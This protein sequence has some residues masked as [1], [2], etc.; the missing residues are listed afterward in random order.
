MNF[1]RFLKSGFLTS[2]LF[3]LIT[4][5]NVSAIVDPANPILDPLLMKHSLYGETEFSNSGGSTSPKNG[6][7]GTYGS[8]KNPYNQF[9]FYSKTFLQSLDQGSKITIVNATDTLLYKNNSASTTFMGSGT[10]IQTPNANVY[11]TKPVF[12]DLSSGLSFTGANGS[13]TAPGTYSPGNYTE[14][15]PAWNANT[16]T[17]TAG[18]YYFGKISIGSSKNIVIAPNAG[19]YLTIIYI[20]NS[21]NLNNNSKIK[22]ADSTGYGQVLFMYRG[23]SDFT[24]VS[25][26]EITGT[27]IAPNAKIAFDNG[28]KLY[29]QAMGNK[30]QLNGFMGNNNLFF[31]PWNPSKISLVGAS[32]FSISEDNDGTPTSSDAIPDTRFINIPVELG[33][34]MDSA[35]SVQYEIIEYTGGNKALIGTD[36]TL[37]ESPASQSGT[38]NFPKNSTTSTDSI[39][40]KIIDDLKTAND[41]NEADTEYFYLN[42]FNPQVALLE[43]DASADKIAYK[44]DGITV[45][46]LYYKIPI[47][48]DDFNEAPVAV[49]DTITV[50]E[51]DTT[52]LSLTA[53]DTDPDGDALTVTAVTQGSNG[54]V[55]LVA[56]VVTYIHDDSETP[57]TDNFTYTIEDPSGESS[58]ATVYLNITPVNDNLPVTV[59]DSINVNEGDSTTVLTTG[60][61]SVLTNDH[62]DDYN[63]MS[64]VT[65]I[66]DS[67]VSHASSFTL[68]S[69]GTFSYTHDGTE[70]FTDQFTYKTNDGVG[71]GNTVTVKITINPVNDNDPVAVNDSINVDEG[72]STT[73]LTNSNTNLKWNDTDADLPNDAL[74]YSL[75]TDATYGKATIQPNGTFKYVHYGT[76]NF[77]DSFTYKVTDGLGH[78][79]IGTVNITI[80]PVNDNTPIANIDTIIVNEGENIQVL[81]GGQNSVLWNDSDLDSPNDNLTT[82][83]VVGSS[84]SNASDFNLSLNGTFTYTHNGSENFAD[85]FKYKVIDQKG[86]T[87]TALVVIIINPVN[88][89]KPIA[90][91]DSINVNEGATKTVLVSG[92]TSVLDNDDDLDGMTGVTA[93]LDTDVSHGT[94]TLN[95]DGTFS[96]AHDGSENFTDNFTYKPYDGVQY[97][98]TVTVKIT[99]N[100]QND[101]PPVTVSDSINVDENAIQTVLV[102]GMT[103]VLFNDSDIDGMTGVTAV[104]VTDVSNGTLTLNANGTFSYDHDGSENFTDSFTY[105]TNDGAQDGD[106]VIVNITINPINDNTPVAVDD[107]ISLNEEATATT[108]TGGQNNVT[109][110]DTDVDL[111]NDAFTTSVVT[112]VSN[113]SLNLNLDGTFSYQH[114]GSENFSDS[115]TY[116]VKDEVGHVDTATV[117]ITIAPINDNIP[118]AGDDAIAVNQGTAV[119]TLMGGQTSVLWNDNDGDNGDLLTVTTTPITDVTNGTL[120]L[121][122]D[123]TFLYTHDGSG[124]LD[125]LFK[126]EV[127]DQANHKDTATVSISAGATNTHTPVAVKDSIYTTEGNTVTVLVSNNT[128]VLTNDTDA[129]LPYDALS[130]IL[131]TDVAYGTLT[132]DSSGT[133]SYTHDGSE[134]F[135]DSFVYKVVDA[136]TPAH[137]SGNITVPIKIDPVNDNNPVAVIDTIFVKEGETVDTLKGGGNN[138]LTNDSDLDFGDA[139]TMVTPA[140][141]DVSHGSLTLNANGTFEYTHDDSENFTDQFTYIV[142]DAVNNQATAIVTIIITPTNDNAPVTVADSIYMNEGDTA[143]TLVS[144]NT[145]VL[146]NDSDIDGM[147]FGPVT[148]LLTTDVVNGSLTLNTDGT[149]EYIHDGTETIVDSFSYKTHDG[150]VDGNTVTVH[151][152]IDP[153]NNNTPVAVVDTIFVIEGGVVDTL[154]NGEVNLLANDSDLDLPNDALTISLNSISSFGNLSL[155]QTGTFSYTHDGSENFLDSFTYK[156]TDANSHSSIAEVVIIVTPVNDNTPVANSDTIIVNEDAIATTLK[157]SA[158]SLLSNDADIDLGDSLKVDTILTNVAFGSLTVNADGTFSYDHDGTEN[159]TDEFTYQISDGVDHHSIATVTIVVNPVNNNAPVSI[160]DSIYLNEGDTSTLLVT[161]DSSVLQ[162]DS[163]IDGMGTV[164]A[165]LVVG[166]TYGTITL[167]PNGTF[168]YIHDDS[169]NFIDAFTYKANDGVQAGN[170]VTV[171]IQIEPVNDNIPDGVTDTIIISE[172]ETVTLLKDS[173]TSLLN[174]DSDGDINTTLTAILTDSANYG[175]ILIYEDGTFKYIHD[176]SENFTDTI[177]YI[178]TDGLFVSDT[179]VLVINITPVNDNT[180]IAVSDTIEVIEGGTVSILIDSSTSVLDNDSDIDGMIGSKVILGDIPVLGSLT[181]N[182]DGTFT[183]IHNGTENYSDEFS[184]FIDDGDFK[185]NEVNVVIKIIPIQKPVSLNRASYFDVDANGHIDNVVFE[186]KKPINNIDTMNITLKWDEVNSEV[187]LIPAS[188]LIHGDNLYSVIADVADL[189]NTTLRTGGKMLASIYYK[190]FDTTIV[191]PTAVSDKAA[192]VIVNAEYKFNQKKTNTTTCNKLLVRLSEPAL[193]INVATPFVLNNEFSDYKLYLSNMKGDSNIVIYEVDSVFAADYVNKGDSIRIDYTMNISDNLSNI[194]SVDLNRKVE[195]L[196]EEQPFIFSIGVISQTGATPVALHSD[197]LI[198][199]KA[200]FGTAITLFP[201]IGGIDQKVPGYLVDK[202][203]FEVY[204]FDAVGNIVDF[205]DG[206]DYSS[207]SIFSDTKTI[208]GKTGIIINWTNKNNNGRD[209]GSGSYVAIIRVKGDDTFAAEYKSK[210]SVKDFE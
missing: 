175:E 87:D 109:W 173:I 64:V 53:N 117:T 43:V 170:V 103:T 8:F 190:E 127:T 184:Y 168:T 160:G 48:N 93:V 171:K 69:N 132:L 129:D 139:L 196:I 134:N 145:S 35:S 110:N 128:S 183:Y 62:D 100:A 172:G 193:S 16:I 78:F 40:I 200:K 130:A 30:I 27:I 136:A 29:G 206:K 113:G 146:D 150:E 133:F 26:A 21:F 151:I 156:V 89:N 121:N 195:I 112:G 22:V 66:L 104:L 25:S 39:W 202:L 124:N 92:N 114:N 84:A 199:N 9:S 38:I 95:S 88:D 111:P 131:V 179:V 208:D 13:I 120:T 158:T 108:L 154:S 209:V 177:K 61:T 159:F 137:V 162:N 50:L 41:A 10:T 187:Y 194:Q 7:T 65:A 68:N 143:T 149:F 178:A 85:S 91:K 36:L 207:K 166:V 49:N 11:T 126:Y 52:I 60:A 135:T 70:N 47:I 102:S 20:N 197:L 94:L 58:T 6:I 23:T 74:T 81:K 32:T 51:G 144:S 46:T 24:L 56:G 185:S 86:H 2:F 118:D 55:T 19:S 97:G 122:A 205:S 3:I 80:N 182:A 44:A 181:L 17:L 125:D 67:T 176:G 12:P 96:Y 77:I 157:T 201:N 106:T 82:S 174:N 107:A 163:D 192:P 142:K 180:P 76:E 161:G 141:S 115:F 165:E 18:I 204:I 90:T 186:F 105:K 42:L 59:K 147:N 83:V 72:D 28:A 198:N 189:F 31:K 191:D 79:D 116:E 73:E 33:G 1:R 155:L 203:D 34:P 14:L 99:V 119:D 54:T 98:T 5:E 153:I 123:G 57:L 101:N 71:D 75:E 4:F 37:T 164:T 15:N 188:N 45:D 138:L 148:A 167:N 63:G 140:A 169:E 210:M 152:K